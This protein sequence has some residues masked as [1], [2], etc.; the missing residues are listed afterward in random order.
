MKRLRRVLIVDRNPLWC[1]NLMEVLL[2]E[3]ISVQAVSSVDEALNKLREEFYHLII[4]DIQMGEDEKRNVEGFQL[5]DSLIFYGIE[6]VIKVIVLTESD[7]KD[8]LRIAFRKYHVSDFLSKVEFNM[9]IFVESV[10]HAFTKEMRHNFMLDIVWQQNCGPETIV[11]NFL[12]DGTSLD[13]G[14]VLF[15]R[16]LAELDDLLCQLFFRHKGL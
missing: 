2:R 10:E 16:V 5:L 7:S 14:N 13:Y 12:F 6:N 8:I 11:R 9:K 3:C 15:N 4:L 1:E